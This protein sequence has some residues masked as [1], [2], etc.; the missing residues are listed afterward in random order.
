MLGKEISEKNLKVSSKK[1]QQKFQVFNKFQL[2]NLDSTKVKEGTPFLKGLRVSYD[3][4][5]AVKVVLE[6][7]KKVKYKT[8]IDLYSGELFIDLEKVILSDE[9]KRKF[10]NNKSIRLYEIPSKS[11]AR[12]VIL[13]KGIE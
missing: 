3:D 11:W 1:E 2:K 7:D 6:S 9:L 10:S 5:G 13:K 8:D 4:K 12:L